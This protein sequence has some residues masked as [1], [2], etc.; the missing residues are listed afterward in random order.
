M[1]VN[2]NVLYILA[3]IGVMVFVR[4]YYE[5]D[6]ILTGSGRTNATWVSRGI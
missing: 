1:N 6:R 3:I 5:G 2:I 4:P